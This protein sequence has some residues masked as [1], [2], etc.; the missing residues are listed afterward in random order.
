MIWACEN[1]DNLIFFIDYLGQL[2]EI[3]KVSKEQGSK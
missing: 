2:I 1:F 3:N